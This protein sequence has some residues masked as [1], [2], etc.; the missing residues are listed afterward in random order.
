MD[1]ESVDT[2]FLDYCINDYFELSRFKRQKPT[3]L[4]SR[5]LQNIITNPDEEKFKSLGTSKLQQKWGMEVF[6]KVQ[7]ILQ[8]VG[9]TMKG[10]RLIFT[11][12]DTTGLEIASATI[13]EK[14]ETEE[15]EMN[16][17]RAAIKQKTKAKST[18]A[19]SKKEQKKKALF[20]KMKLD[21]KNYESEQAGK[22]KEGSK[23]KKINFGRKDVAV[24][25]QTSSGG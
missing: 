2:A 1:S 12:A 22:P 21:R 6:L 9:F 18:A 11:Q 16:A 25:F 24:E 3:K 20:E 17:Q 19:L 23:A 10:D 15:A 7:S 5:I 4:L 8:A 14:N 13:L